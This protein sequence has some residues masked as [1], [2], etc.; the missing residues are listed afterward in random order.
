MRPNFALM[1]SFEGI[2][3]LHRTHAG[4][5]LVGEVRLD[6]A[7]LSGDLAELAGKARALDPTGLRSKLVIPDE[8]IKYLG[9]DTEATDGDQIER[10]VRSAL[11]GATPYTLA[12]LSYDWSMRGGHV[13]VAAVARE[14]LAEAEDFA[15]EHDFN[16]MC[17]VAMPG[18]DVFAGEP[19]FG[20]TKHAGRVLGPDETIARED[21]VIRIV[22]AAQ[23]PEPETVTEEEAPEPVETPPPAPQAEED[24]RSM[25]EGASAP[26]P[27]AEATA[28]A[29]A[30][31]AKGQK[32]APKRGQKG[33][34]K[35]QKGRGGAKA[36]PAD[37]APGGKAAANTAPKARTK[38]TPEKEKPHTAPQS[39]PETEKAVSFTSIRPAG[40]KEDDARRPE[41]PKAR[42]SPPPVAADEPGTPPKKPAI[43]GIASG[44]L[45]GE[46]R[47]RKPKAKAAASVPPAPAEPAPAI[48]SP[49]P[50][51]VRKAPAGPAGKLGALFR[52]MARKAPPA[53]A[54][55]K[56]PARSDPSPVR[57]GTEMA[58]A[59]MPL[60][61]DMARDEKERLTI[62]GA[63]RAA[64]EE[65]DRPRYVA[66][67]LTAILLLILVAVA[68][69]AAL[70]LEGG[71]SRVFG[72][73]DDVRVVEDAKP[74][75]DPAPED[76][77]AGTG[78]A[79]R[80]TPGDGGAASDPA[81][82]D[83]STGAVQPQTDGT[84]EDATTAALNEDGAQSPDPP[85]DDG[86]GTGGVAP[87]IIPEELTPDEARR[88]YAAT[89]IWQMA[90][91]PSTA[92][93]T[94]TL[95]EV[96]KTSPD[97]EVQLEDK[98]ELPAPENLRY[99]A[100][101]PRPGNPP[102]PLTRFELD[103]RGFIAATPE[104][105]ETPDGVMVYAG[106]PP[107]E[108]PPTPPRAAPIVLDDP[109]AAA[110]E[111]PTL[112]PRV[113]PED[114]TGLADPAAPVEGERQT[115]L[116]TDTDSEADTE[117]MLADA[118][119]EAVAVSLVPRARPE[120]FS[121]IVEDTR[122]AVASD[123]VSPDQ[124]LAAATPSSVSVARAATEDNRI[125]LREVNLIGVYGTPESRRA[126]VRLA[127]G[128]Y[129]KLQVG[130][131][132]DG[133]RVAAIGENQL[134]YVKRGKSVMLKMPDG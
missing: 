119:E 23:L 4:W 114:L 43:S 21:E 14:T 82:A 99:A 48:Q 42:F 123:P 40:G 126:L 92:P 11:D 53:P 74:A 112:R 65:P 24:G 60:T 107:I 26:E 41:L 75:P 88:R 68:A 116:A 46:E 84:A 56:R 94:T 15:L 13:H 29:E 55:T 44:S 122:N 98:A 125:A 128:R 54:A 77:T 27:P 20:E 118:T 36:G 70:F 111:E 103:E 1:L 90:P 93:G 7:T 97:P 61:A 33:K 76:E 102:P 66:L 58:A 18:E 49:G 62:F 109:T 12:E 91:P 5:H 113:R 133:G 120:E 57:P 39:P 106:S 9:F 131:R 45:P 86:A 83:G 121:E 101:P 28:A 78:A 19:Y 3:L 67:I 34:N 130:D 47:A 105:T 87:E 129:R 6:S 52:R 30:P 10:E 95:R 127:N 16:P 37:P 115:D 63:R 2:S 25:E 108:P 72:P 132:L 51:T 124:R 22:G 89:G 80:D 81:T 8:Q 35:Q 79:Q 69:W 117:A 73:S 100:H 17:F 96:Y 59:P 110:P 64:S 50:D 104:G 32:G 31:E 134:R 71:L 38:D 85:R